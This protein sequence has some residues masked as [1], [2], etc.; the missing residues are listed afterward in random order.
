MR[1]PIRKMGGDGDLGLGVKLETVTKVTAQSQTQQPLDQA[2]LR[3]ARGVGQSSPDDQPPRPGSALAA[4]A[5][6]GQ[7]IVPVC[8]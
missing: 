5:A 6:R 3:R 7:Y 2:G 8:S 1:T 4:L